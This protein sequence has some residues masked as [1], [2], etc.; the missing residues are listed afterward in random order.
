MQK[1]INSTKS[2]RSTRVILDPN[3]LPLFYK[4]FPEAEL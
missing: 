4:E 3:F 2:G 1:H